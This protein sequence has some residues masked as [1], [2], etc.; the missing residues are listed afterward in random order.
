MSRRKRRPPS[1]APQNSVEQKPAAINSHRWYL[2]AGALIVITAAGAWWMLR[3]AAPPPAAPP[4]AA[5]PAGRPS[6][7]VPVVTATFVGSEACAGCHDK[8]YAAW[9]DSHHARAMQHATADTVLGNFAHASFRY[10]G[11]ESTFFQRDGK[12]FVH[13]DGADGKLKDFEIKYTFGVDPLQ[14]YLIEFPDG[15]IQA[16]SIAWD[17]RPAAQG[18]QRWFHL[19]PN[20]KVDSRDELHWTRYSQNWNF[21][22]ADCHS[23][24][25]HKNYDAASNTFHTTYK[26]I[27]VGCEACHGPGSAH[28][29]WART[30]PKDPTQGLTVALTERDGVHWTHR[31]GDRQP[32][33]QQPPR[34]GHR[35]SKSARNAIRGAV[36]SPTVITPDCLSST[37]IG[38]RCCHRACIMPTASSATR[39]MSGARSC[40]AACITPESPAATATSRTATSCA[41]R[42]MRSAAPATWRRST[43]LRHIIIMRAPD[44]AR[45][46]STATCRSG[47]TWW[48]IRGAITACAFRAPTSPSSS[49]C[50][51]PAAAA[52]RKPT[53]VG[54]RE[55]RAVVRAPAR[56]LSA[57]R[58]GVRPRG[59]AARRKAGRESRG[60]GS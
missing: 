9:K 4:S 60:P 11:V 16:L 25:V 18:G 52:M 8:A 5:A 43:R 33:A 1:P 50:R 34:H 40:R 31:C 17:S 55:A 35:N 13:T 26:E 7:S 24:D 56:R 22:C 21:M 30:K 46:A 39:S 29:E 45:A 54:G 49:A 37:S 48:S 23:T 14:Q 27:S 36:R 57:L 15:R 44:P 19:Y 32:G 42:A 53:P 10:A 2:P 12:Y 3:P 41:P 59:A 47:P 6:P 28:L 51:M 58:R 20:D 38:R